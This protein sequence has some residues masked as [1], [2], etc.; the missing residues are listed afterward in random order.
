MTT[1]IKTKSATVY[2]MARRG[3]TWPEVARLRVEIASRLPLV[4]APFL[5]KAAARELGEILRSAVEAA[6]FNFPRARVTIT[7]APEAEDTTTDPF[8]KIENWPDLALPAAVALLKA[9]GQTPGVQ[10][11][12]TLYVG[13]LGLDGAVRPVSRG[14]LWLGLLSAVM[15]IGAASPP[16]IVRYFRGHKPWYALRTLADLRDPASTALPASAPET[17]PP[18]DPTDRF[19][20]AD[21]TA[22]NPMLVLTT[23]AASLDRPLILVGPAG[24]GKS[25]VARRIVGTMKAPTFEERRQIALRHDLAGLTPEDLPG[26]PFRAPHHTVS[27]RG[28]RSEIELA[29]GGI[30]LLEDAAEFRA[31]DLPRT[32]PKDVRVILTADSSDALARI[33]TF[34]IAAGAVVCP[35]ERGPHRMPSSKDIRAWIFG[36]APYPWTNGPGVEPW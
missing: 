34:P 28:L 30:L 20:M 23:L 36:E 29:K 26:R 6:G 16:E 4:D 21:W 9:T 27:A 25:M 18:E 32:T 12:D 11:D 7:L 5:P 15:R 13:S 19:D 2:T 24:C 33:L 3:G 22:A 35:I 14:V 8:Q 1:E 31:H 10:D 17:E